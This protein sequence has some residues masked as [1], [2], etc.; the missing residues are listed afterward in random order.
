MSEPSPELPHPQWVYW[1]RRGLVLAVL[2]LLI[3]GISKFFSKAPADEAEPTVTSS[4][5]AQ[6]T[7]SEPETPPTEQPTEPATPSESASVPAVT[8]KPTPT[9]TPSPQGTPSCELSELKLDLVG[10]NR[11]VG[12]KPVEYQI[13]L[14][15]PEKC[16]LDFAANELR[17]VITSGT[18]RIWTSDHCPVFKKPTTQVVSDKPVTAK[19]TWPVKRSNK[20]CTLRPHVLQPGTY[21]AKASIGEDTKDAIVV[22]LR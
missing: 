10:P 19:I 6:N 22:T 7:P 11:V 20:N 16:T 13:N 5:P 8:P 17:F 1:M 12:T 21:V 18:D 15:S 2:L 9:P 14:T 3:W 4:A